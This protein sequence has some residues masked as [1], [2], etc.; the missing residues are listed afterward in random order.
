M[1]ADPEVLQRATV[2]TAFSGTASGIALDEF[3]LELDQSKLTGKV[4]VSDFE[5]L[6]MNFDLTVDQIDLDRYMAPAEDTSEEDVAIPKE[7]LKGQT[8]KGQLN[9]G[10]LQM[11]G[12]EFVDAQVGLVVK[13][14]KLF[15]QSCQHVYLIGRKT[16][17]D[18]LVF[19]VRCIGF[20]L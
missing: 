18:Y 16:F 7:E 13:N 6:T 14:G 15:G 12:L 9:V 5:Q 1:T 20:E 2:V 10:Q 8:V 17:H 3:E 11:L 4:S 19:L